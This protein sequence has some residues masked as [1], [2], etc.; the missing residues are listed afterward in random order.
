MVAIIAEVVAG[1]VTN[2]MATPVAVFGLALPVAVALAVAIAQWWQVRSARAEP[3]SWW[4]LAGAA[5]AVFIWIVYPTA[6]G[7]LSPAG[8]PR[9]ACTI[10]QGAHMT[11]SCMAS[12]TTAY[13]HRSLVWWLTG[14]LILV[15]ALL[16]R[17]SRIAAWAAIPAALGGVLIATHFLELLLLRY[18]G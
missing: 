1:I 17:R 7:I 5:A 13:A 14:A 10:M 4:H 3:A 12:A 11:H 2:S 6:P 8:S 16:T 9:A 15:T 18:S